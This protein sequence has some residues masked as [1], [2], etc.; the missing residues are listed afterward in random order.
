MPD[1]RPLT[2]FDVADP[3]IPV[4]TMVDPL[5]GT[6]VA[7]YVVT[8]PRGGGVKENVMDEASL[9]LTVSA[10]GDARRV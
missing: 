2:V 7:V 6:A 9:P 8:D 5:V 10:D 1:C 4:L 3:L